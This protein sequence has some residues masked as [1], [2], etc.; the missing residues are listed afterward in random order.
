MFHE[1]IQV[2]MPFGASS[3]LF[4]PFELACS[5]HS[6]WSVGNKGR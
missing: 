2:P 4:R 3:L 1:R 6:T 5:V